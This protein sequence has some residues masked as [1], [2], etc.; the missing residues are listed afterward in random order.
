MNCQNFLKP[1]MAA[2]LTLCSIV[3]ATVLNAPKASADDYDNGN[4]GRYD[5]LRYPNSRYCNP[6]RD[7][8][9]RNQN[10]DWRNQSQNDDWRNQNSD[11]RN[12]G[13]NDDWSDRS[14]RRENYRVSSGV[15]IPTHAVRQGRIV[16]RKG[17][18]YSYQLITD[19]DLRADSGNRTVIPRG[20]VIEGELVPYRDGY[21]F[22]S[23]Y[24]NLRN[25]GR[26]N[27]SAVSNI[28][29]SKDRYS[30]GVGSVFSPA[31]SVIL[32]TILGRPITSG[33]NDQW[34]SIFDRDSRARRDLVVIYPN[35]DLD[36]RLNRD[37]KLNYR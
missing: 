14:D 20:S 6:N 27:I 5:C 16:L 35:R 36:L 4:N 22:E 9:W 31:A 24:V 17:E 34:G 12:R 10:D 19:Q 30:Q 3:P 8:D 1:M 18:Q 37:F 7:N 33:S 25:G 32:G 21:R 2:A 11:W 13:R 26:E 29:D 23:R 15:L 28:I